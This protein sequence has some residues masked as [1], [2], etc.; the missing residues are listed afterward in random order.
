MWQR[1]AFFA[2]AGLLLKPNVVHVLAAI[3]HITKHGHGE[4]RAC[5]GNLICQT[6][7]FYP[8]CN[9]TRVRGL[10]RPEFKS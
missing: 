10:A 1:S 7:H 4:N 6:Q 9:C 3:L 8:G 2:R 5:R